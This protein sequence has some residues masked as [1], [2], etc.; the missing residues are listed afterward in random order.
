MNQLTSIP[1]NIF[2]VFDANL[3]LEAHGLFLDLPKT[4]GIVWHKGLPQVHFAIM[5]KELFL[6]DKLQY[7]SL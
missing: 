7:V 1:H 4:F 5:G 2:Q 3:L 6:V